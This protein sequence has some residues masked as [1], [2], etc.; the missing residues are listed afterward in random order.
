[1]FSGTGFITKEGRPAAIYAGLSDP[2]HTHIAVANDNQ[3]S[4]WEK[5]YPVLPKGG[6]DGK[7]MGLLNEDPQDRDLE[8]EAHEPGLSRGAGESNLGT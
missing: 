3:L 8:V 2:G 1:M 5:P 7:N 6:P 4:S